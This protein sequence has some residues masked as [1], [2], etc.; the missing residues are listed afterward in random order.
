MQP[1]AQQA[2]G[3]VSQPVVAQFEQPQLINLRGAIARRKSS[4]ASA[5]SVADPIEISP[6]TDETRTTTAAA[7][8]LVRPRARGAFLAGIS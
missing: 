8:T 1:D 6:D 4:F 3:P 7:T 2:P 5:C